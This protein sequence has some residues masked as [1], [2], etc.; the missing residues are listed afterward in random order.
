MGVVDLVVLALST[1]A[2]LDVWLDEDSIL[3]ERRAVTQTWRSYFWR[4]LLNCRF[5][6]SYWVPLFP[7]SLYLFSLFVPDSWSVAVRL[8][9]YSLAATGLVRILDQV[10]DIRGATTKEEQ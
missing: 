6:L 7:T 8:P 5:C 3:A 4:T 2:C 9:V 10:L 1:R